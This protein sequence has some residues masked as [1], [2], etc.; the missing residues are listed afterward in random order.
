MNI[1]LIAGMPGVGKTTISS[2]LSARYNAPV[3]CK[4]TFKE[5]LCDEV[6]FTCAEEKDNLD[7]GATKSMMVAAKAI[8]A[9]GSSVILESNFSTRDKDY[10]AQLEKQGGARVVTLRIDCDMDILYKRVI[11]RDQDPNRHPPHA[12]NT[13]YPVPEGERVEYAPMWN[14]QEFTQN[15]EQTGVRYFCYGPTVLANTSDFSK[16]DYN[17]IAQQ[18]DTYILNNTKKEI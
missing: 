8:L 6:G 15:V 17:L 9:M 11:T 12:T 18:L 3:L 5:V 13:R 14:Q 7:K 2:F 4:D 1:L 10:S 16:V